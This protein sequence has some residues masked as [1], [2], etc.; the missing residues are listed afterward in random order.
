[1]KT[2]KEKAQNEIESL[3][4]KGFDDAQI[5]NFLCDGEALE[6][7]GYTDENLVSE[8]YEIVKV[9]K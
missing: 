5:K 7:E 1:M 4:E 2:L 8:M 9:S 3:R 6:A